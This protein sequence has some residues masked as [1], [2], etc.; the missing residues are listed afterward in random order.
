MNSRMVT[1]E[2]WGSIGV[3]NVIDMN[4]VELAPEIKKRYCP[5]YN[6]LPESNIIDLY[7]DI[8][9]PKLDYVNGVRNM[10]V[11]DYST[12]L[13]TEHFHILLNNF[14]DFPR[15]ID[16]V[17]LFNNMKATRDIPYIEIVDPVSSERIHKFHINP[18]NSTPILDEDVLRKW[19]DETVPNG[20]NFVFIKLLI[21][22]SSIGEEL[23]GNVYIHNNGVVEFIA[24]LQD[25]GEVFDTL[26][27]GNKILDR[28]FK[29]LEDGVINFMNMDYHKYVNSNMKRA[30]TTNILNN[31]PREIHYAPDVSSK[32]KYYNSVLTSTSSKI[33]FQFDSSLY[34]SSQF[35]APLI[36]CLHPFVTIEN[37]TVRLN[38]SVSFRLR[39]TDDFRLNGV[40]H[41]VLLNGRYDIVSD[42]GESVNVGDMVLKSGG[43]GVADAKVY[44]T[45]VNVTEDTINLS[46]VLKN[47]TVDATRTLTP[48]DLSEYKLYY[49]RVAL[50][51]INVEGDLVV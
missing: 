14:I 15:H 19:V 3:I 11:T 13:V 44:W 30:D 47:G 38:Q 9:Y 17:V 22:E 26:E 32:F 6:L 40:I 7:N 21:K 41:D 29:L 25:D 45:V 4:A 33:K 23:Y 37:D 51:N 20:K 5:K 1:L 28:V 27:E 39:T 10:T 48:T 42:I 46:H 50:Y 8:V 12:S 18:E 49:P 16:T 24:D 34:L 36:N 31:I 35:F 43:K 2:E